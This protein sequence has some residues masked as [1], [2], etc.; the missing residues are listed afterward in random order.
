[1][2]NLNVPIVYRGKTLGILMLVASQLLIGSIHSVFGFWL[3][4][5]PKIA[6][7]IG[8]TSAPDIYSIYTI[9]FGLLTLIFAAG[10]WLTKSWGWVG[11]VAVA[12]FVT[13]AD[14]LTLLDLPSVPGIPKLA[15]FLEI[16]YSLLILLYL[17]QPHTR[18]MF[19]ICA[20]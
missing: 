13:V 10:L 4:S 19:K 8:N 20:S 17:L 3:L 12:F 18:T 15:C 1:M 9:V 7:F 16:S 2:S 5:T 14:T 11:T 6:P